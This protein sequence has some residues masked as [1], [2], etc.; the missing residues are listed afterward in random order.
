[1]SVLA[2]QLKTSRNRLS[3]MVHRPIPWGKCNESQ[4]RIYTSLHEFIHSNNNNNNN[5]PAVKNK[6][7]V[8]LRSNFTEDQAR[9]L[10][11]SFDQNNRP[12]AE[13]RAYLAQDLKIPLPL[14]TRFFSNRRRFSKD[15]NNK[16]QSPSKDDENKSPIMN[17]S[18]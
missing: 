16:D 18:T 11:E 17:S 12:S 13:F 7:S 4:S 6:K 14:V 8:K 1:M 9:K 5:K 2:G 15:S 10:K 3:S